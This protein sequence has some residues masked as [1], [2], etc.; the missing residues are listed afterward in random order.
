MDEFIPF[1]ASVH[2]TQNY[3]EISKKESV[4]ISKKESEKEV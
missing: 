4:E 1:L 3:F 2:R